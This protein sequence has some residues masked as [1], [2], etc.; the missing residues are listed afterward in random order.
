M[1]NLKPDSWLYRDVRKKIED[2]FLGSGDQDSLV[3]YYQNWMQ[4]NPNDVE[5]MT[6]LAKFL[7]SSARIPEATQWMEKALTLAPS[8][9]DLRKAYIDQLLEEQ[10]VTDA[11]V[12]YEK[13]VASE[14]SNVDYLRDWGKLVLKDKSRDIEVR[15]REATKIWHRIVQLRPDDAS[16]RSLVADY[17]RLAN[18]PREATS[19]YEKAVELAPNEP[20]YREYLGEFL[21]QQNR[22][23]DAIRTWESIAQGTRRSADNVARL[24]EV[25]K[26][27]GFQ[28][29]AVAEIAEAC[30]L[31]PKDF[32]LQLD[33]AELH[34][35]AD[36]FDEALSYVSAAQLLAGN[37]DEREMVL[38]QRIEILQSSQRLES[39]IVQLAIAIRKDV[40]ATA[41]QWYELA[42]YCETDR[43]WPLAQQAIGAALKIEKESIPFLTTAAKIAESSGDLG[44]AT[45]LCRRL[46]AID[47]RSMADHLANIAKYEA[48]LGHPN[49]AMQAARDLIVSAPGNTDHYE[50]FAQL[51]FRLNKPTEGLDS[52]RKAIRINPNEPYLIM[53]LGAALA[54]NRKTEEA[55][56]IYWRAFEKSEN[57]DDK[58]SLITKLVPL[59]QERKQFSALI[60]RLQLRRRIEDQRRESTICMA[61]AYAT[62]SD[63][64]KAR[65][66]L[67]SLLGQDTRDTN[68]LQQ[69]AKICSDAK[70]LTAAIKYQRQL[71]AIAPGSE[72][73]MP[74]AK[75]LQANGEQDEASEILIGLAR[76]EDDPSRLLKTIDSLISQVSLEPAL[77]ITTPMLRQQRDHWELLYREGVVYAM[78]SN[79][80]QARA[81]FQQLLS[82]R[83]PHDSLSASAD[84]KFKKNQSKA[85]SE[86]LKGNVTE[87]P[88]RLSPFDML[89]RTGKVTAATN[90]TAE[91]LRILPPTSRSQ[92]LWMPDAFGLARM[93]AYA[94]LMKFDASDPSVQKMVD[95][96]K[97]LET[98]LGGMNREALFD[99]LYVASLQSNQQ[100]LLRVARLISKSGPEEHEFYLTRLM[101]R[102]NSENS[103]QGVVMSEGSTPLTPLSAEDIELMVYCVKK[104]QRSKLIENTPLTSATASS[105]T[106]SAQLQMALQQQAMQR[107]ILMQQQ[108]MQQMATQSLASSGPVTIST[109]S[110]GTI[111]VSS[112]MMSQIF[113]G[114][115]IS[116]ATPTRNNFLSTVWEELR[117]AG[118]GQQA[119]ELV[120]GFATSATRIEEMNAIMNLCL[121]A[122]RLEEL[123]KHYPAWSALAKDEISK[124]IIVKPASA[125]PGLTNV[126]QGV[127]GTST[128]WLV[129]WMGML[130]QE[131]RHEDI[132]A[133]LDPALD[134]AILNS[135]QIRSSR[136]ILNRQR[137][138]AVR[139][140]LQPQTNLLLSFGS[141]MFYASVDFPTQ[142]DYLDASVI[143]LLREVYE[144][145]RRN[146]SEGALSTH[147]R[148]RVAKADGLV[149]ANEELFLA[150]ALWWE[151]QK[152][153]ALESMLLAT[154][155]LKDDAQFQ[156][157]IA[158][159]LERQ[160]DFGRAM[161]LVEAI[162]PS[163]ASTAQ[164]KDWLTV[165]L[166]WRLG[167]N[168]QSAEAAERLA[169]GKLDLAT[170]MELANKLRRIGMTE[171]ANTVQQ[172]VRPTPR[173]STSTSRLSTSRPASTSIQSAKAMLLRSPRQSTVYS[174]G[175]AITRQANDPART[176]ALQ[177]L[178]TSGELE[179][180]IVELEG[181]FAKSPKEFREYDQLVEFYGHLSQKQKAVDLFEKALSQNPES[182]FIRAKYADYTAH[183]GNL[184]KAC[185]LYSKVLQD[186]PDVLTD[187]LV[188]V[189]SSFAQ[190]NRMTEI[191]ESLAK[192]DVKKLKNNNEMYLFVNV[193]WEDP[194]VHDI[195][196]Q[197]FQELFEAVPAVRGMLL[198]VLTN[199]RAAP[200]VDALIPTVQQVVVPTDKE[201]DST[202]WF[203]LHDTQSLSV[204]GGTSG[205]FGFIS[206]SLKSDPL[207]T[208]VEAIRA[209][210]QQEPRWLAG[211][212]MVDMLELK[213]SEIKDRSQLVNQLR[214]L[215]SKEMIASL[216][217]NTCWNTA[218]ELVIHQ[219]TKQIAL[220]LYER[221]NQLAP[222]MDHARTA[223]PLS[224]SIQLCNELGQRD[225]A[226]AILQKQ[227]LAV[228]IPSLQVNSVDLRKL[229]T[230]FWVAEKQIEL[231]FALDAVQVY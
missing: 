78:Q 97:D 103:T 178:K 137:S 43:Q 228:Q 157:E 15:N 224:K 95:Q 9:A 79:V 30:K 61:Q 52:L 164:R 92:I 101:M 124:G 28:D 83:L 145:C 53:T 155:L 16:V 162:N 39:S 117:L 179:K 70:D 41:S 189:V 80:E 123:A 69:L 86:N 131:H 221:A 65:A 170:G 218:R 141:E 66:E 34:A 202:A 223:T 204:A 144:V 114:T 160:G 8:R 121:G 40:N 229:E 38:K 59:Y 20:Q 176:Q 190:T 35:R 165:E 64:A 25:F 126:P 72:T 210:S 184:A 220:E 143:Q 12:E 42:R 158:S 225:K 148:K 11:I 208:V 214:E 181:N 199:P 175:R 75:M 173:T 102:G 47:R 207:Q 139:S 135:Q 193:L 68:L 169:A 71:V 219:D 127:I 111:V 45:E 186:N 14:P 106:P 99:F 149:R 216:G 171:L 192:I 217:Y 82:I 133:V 19:L 122:N 29:R 100:D 159:L 215:L 107:Q 197:K 1:T 227:L 156:L 115:Q 22:T 110:G 196:L 174:N 58:T 74:L 33:G 142:N 151:N 213:K 120:N 17:F 32:A 4:T 172:R 51:C 49:E 201:L 81:S 104:L 87:V 44:K 88:V 211:P 167:E 188:F 63:F 168:E 36:R 10:R 55:V 7:A 129:R 50:F 85:K 226:R 231:G 48:Q 108:A 182:S 62:A 222:S 89:H 37:D 105:R 13:L 154:D 56:E 209:R 67:E 185:D 177:I 96:S 113:S 60:D 6:R 163:D 46:A 161:D 27:F 132:L 134:L 5:A 166:A 200:S 194:N 205:V 212:A 150:A 76:R 191:K 73:E 26:R 206:S 153:E 180:M 57:L 3:K 128:D 23:E 195:A 119:D 136:T 146:S 77:K 31:A 198:S 18:L 130:G 90:L 138:V 125:N 54:E 116:S 24:A 112:G 230:I 84:N 152:D 183:Q 187:Q 203:G 118:Q 93:A 109:T 94:W 140:L 147:L 21:H 98:R 2:T 91:Q